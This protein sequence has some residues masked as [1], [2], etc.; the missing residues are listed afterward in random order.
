MTIVTSFI[1][2][3]ISIAAEDKLNKNLKQRLLC[4]VSL[5]HAVIV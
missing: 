1:E 3:W 5:A 2:V 4:K